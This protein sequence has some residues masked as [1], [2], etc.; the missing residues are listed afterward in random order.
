VKGIARKKQKS[1]G[2]RT[3]NRRAEILK[4]YL[5]MTEKTQTQVIEDFI[6]S[7]EEKVNKRKTRG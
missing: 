2:I 4:A 7:L 5:E 3:T 1:I 6:D